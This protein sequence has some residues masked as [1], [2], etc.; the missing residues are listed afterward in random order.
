M[1]LTKIGNIIFL[2]DIF[3]IE[4]VDEDEIN[5]HWGISIS[6][7]YVF[8]KNTKSTPKEKTT[9]RKFMTLKKDTYEKL[10]DISM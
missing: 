8:D 3:K 4:P 2:I 10:G 5:L 9:W 1:V 7:E 6:L